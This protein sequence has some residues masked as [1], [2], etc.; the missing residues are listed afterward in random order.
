MGEITITDKG[1]TRSPVFFRFE[2]AGPGTKP[3]LERRL[4]AGVF[5][6]RDSAAAGP[7]RNLTAIV[8]DS[9]N[10]LPEN[11]TWARAELMNYLRGIDSSTRVA[12]YGLGTR[13]RIYHD[14][15]DDASS[16]RDRISKLTTPVQDQRVTDI[17]EAARQGEDL[18]NSVSEGQRADMEG[19]LTRQIES[20]MLANEHM[21]ERRLKLTLASLEALG[22]HLASIPGRKSLVWIGNG[23]PMMSIT[24]ALGFGARGSVKSYE[25]LIRATSQRLATQGIVLYIVDARGLRGASFA[26]AD[27]ERLQVPGQPRPFEQQ[28]QAAEISADTRQAALKMAAITGGREFLYTNDMAAGV[29]SIADDARGTYSVGFYAEGEPDN[30]W[31]NV[32]LKVNRPGVKLLYRQGYLANAAA[33]TSAEQWSTDHYRTV[34]MNPLGSTAVRFDAQIERGVERGIPVL[35]VTLSISVADL[36]RRKEGNRDFAELEIGLMQKDVSGLPVELSR[37]G[38]DVRMNEAGTQ[39]IET[40]M[41]RHYRAWQL[42][43]RTVSVRIIVRDL[44]G[45]Y[46]TLDIPLKAVPSARTSELP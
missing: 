21:L 45:G 24:G 37:T 31:H 34:A 40:L 43:P 30:K 20:Q 23:V 1:Q 12:L 41:A 16:L 27:I 39:Q 44:R 6:N 5:S 35:T 4:P 29:K 32:S 7:P 46:G 22:N 8:F 33:T 17:A 13:L 36:Y 18:L 9:L 14:F 2:G 28:T 19:M 11:Q 3:A 26:S 25:P 42:D 10:T 15:T 38:L